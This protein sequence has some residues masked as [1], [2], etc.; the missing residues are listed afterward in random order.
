[1]MVV[2]VPVAMV[3][4]MPVMVMIMPLMHVMAVMVMSHAGNLTLIILNS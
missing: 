3:V 1:M 4:A 2:A